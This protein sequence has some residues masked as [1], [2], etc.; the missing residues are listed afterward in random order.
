M[1]NVFSATT[2]KYFVKESTI[3]RLGI[4]TEDPATRRDWILARIIDSETCSIKKPNNR[5]A[6]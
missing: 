3:R 2:N 5:W 4:H 1:I 6:S